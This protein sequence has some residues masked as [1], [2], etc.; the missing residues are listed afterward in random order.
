MATRAATVTN[1]ISLRGPDSMIGGEADVSTYAIFGDNLTGNTIDGAADV[2][3]FA[4]VAASISAFVRDGKTRTMVGGQ[5]APY[6]HIVSSAGVAYGFTFVTSS[7]PQVDLVPKVAS[8]WTTN[9]VVAAG[10][11]QQPAAIVVTVREV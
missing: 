6:Q 3:R 2:F 7:A 10:S 11:F 1:V 9:A 5:V 4:D 8:D